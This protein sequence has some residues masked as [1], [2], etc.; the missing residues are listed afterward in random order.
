MRNGFVALLMLMSTAGTASAQHVLVAA[1]KVVV[2]GQTPEVR[3]TADDVIARL[4]FF[5]RNHDGKVGIDELSERMQPLVTRGDRTSDAA[6]DATEIRDLA[7]APQQIVTKVPNASST[8]RYG[9]GDAVGQSSRSHIENTI[10]DLRLSAEVGEQ[11]K[12]L[13]QAFADEMDAAARAH[14]REAMAPLLMPDA[15]AQF[16]ADLARLENTRVFV[17][18]D[19][20]GSPAQTFVMVGRDPAML[21]RRYQFG[22]EQLKAATAVMETFKAEQQLDDARRSAL[23]GQLSGILNEEDCDNV[24]AALARRPLVKGTGLIA[25]AGGSAALIEA[26][27][28]MMKAGLIPP[29]LSAR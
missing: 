12:G 4:L 5:D 22:P 29:V 23:V 15:L 24:R 3:V 11:A 9:F 6:L 25:V 26:Q 17:M 2:T 14:L 8:G 19:T 16:D 28:M 13:G 10:D 27:L 20:N 18:S 1:Q 7:L 21:L